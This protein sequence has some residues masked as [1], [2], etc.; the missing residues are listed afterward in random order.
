MTKPGYSVTEIGELP[1]DWDLLSM[2]KLATYING[3]AFKPSDWKD[4]G[5][6]IVR[7]ENLNNLQASFNYFNEEVDERYLLD[8]GDILLSWSAS[9]GVYVWNRGKAVLNQ[10]IFKVIPKEGVNKYYLFWALHK[11]VAELSQ[12]THGSTMKHF[13]KRE[14]ETTKIILPPLPE[15]QKIAQILSTADETIQQVTEEITLTERLK[16]G[17][18]QSLLSKGIGHRKF[19]MTEIGEIP[20]KW[21]TEKISNLSQIVTGGTPST[22]EPAYWNG[23]IPWLASGSVHQQH[24]CV[25]S[26]FITK[27][28]FLHSNSKLLPRGTVLI[29]LN[30]QGKTRGMSA[31]LEIEAA[32]NQSLAGIIPKIDLITPVYLLYHL[33]NRYQDIRNISGTGRN[34][35]NLG[36]IKNIVVSCPPI[37][38]QQKISEILSTVDDKLEHLRSRKEH[39]EKLKKGLMDD[40]LTGKVRV[41]KLTQAGG[42]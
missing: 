40:L 9:L 21:E 31:I 18:M 24:I 25:A 34:G 2:S 19:K 7:I 17:L 23:K 5:L 11:A 41:N 20:E 39:L 16:K 8:N 32:C 37:N 38:E 4:K 6:P 42:N 14:L 13:Q 1:D 36:H 10:H 30:G 27:E 12:V 3:M 15:Q 29:A 22:T 35:L 28:G 26:K 33:L